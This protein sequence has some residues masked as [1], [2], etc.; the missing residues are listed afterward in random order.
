MSSHS[1]EVEDEPPYLQV[2][3]E[4]AYLCPTP[5][6]WNTFG[7]AFTQ[8]FDVDNA[9]PTAEETREWCEEYFES[10][11]NN[12]DESVGTDLATS[13]SESDL[14]SAMDGN[15]RRRMRGGRKSDAELI[16]IAKQIHS[17][18][19]PD[20]PEADFVRGFIV[21]WRR[22]PT[23]PK[24]RNDFTFNLGVQ[25]G[26]QLY[27]PAGDTDSDSSGSDIVDAEIEEESDDDDEHKTGAGMSGGAGEPWRP[28]FN[29]YY[30]RAVQ[31]DILSDY[32]EGFHQFLQQRNGNVSE[33]D[34]RM[35]CIAYF[36]WVNG[37]SDDSTP[38]P[39]DGDSDAGTKG[40]ES[41]MDGNGR[42]RIDFFG[43][44][45]PHFCE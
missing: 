17:E 25:I 20:L 19:Y 23:P 39:S 36:N 2:L 8:E 35:W 21:G 45:R 14:D 32:M 3:R 29:E 38:P 5:A 15:G 7:E 34:A 12:P 6:D 40:S 9:P 1:S 33:Q 16:R 13:G 4:Y 24:Y 18:E 31:E 22:E 41:D 10:F 37:G 42:R 26:T 27:D 43:R 44:A 28:V 30:Q 11:D